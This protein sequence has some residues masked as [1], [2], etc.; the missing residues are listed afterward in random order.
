MYLNGRVGQILGPFSAGEDL[1]AEEGAIK[2]LVSQYVDGDERVQ[3]SKIGIQAS[4]GTVVRI[5]DADIKIG[6]TGIYE[7]DEVVTIRKLVFPNGASSSTIV[8]FIY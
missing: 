1:L 7:L 4:E 3:L 8:D 5:N 2:N 6:K